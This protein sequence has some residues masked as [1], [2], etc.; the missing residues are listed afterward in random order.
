METFSVCPPPSGFKDW[1]EAHMANEDL[2]QWVTEKTTAYDFEYQIK[3]QM[4]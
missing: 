4:D 1:N 2:F 3:A